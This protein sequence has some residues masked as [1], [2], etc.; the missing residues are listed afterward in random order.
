MEPFQIEVLVHQLIEIGIR[1]QAAAFA[2][3]ERMGHPS[4]EELTETCE[5]V[6]REALRFLDHFQTQLSPAKTKLPWP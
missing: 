5:R 3:A 2:I 4:G 1:L 6:A